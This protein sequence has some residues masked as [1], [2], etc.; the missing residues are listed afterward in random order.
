VGG[1]VAG[2]VAVLLV[3]G[4]WWWCYHKSEKERKVSPFVVLLDLYGSIDVNDPG[5]ASPSSCQSIEIHWSPLIPSFTHA[6]RLCRLHALD[7]QAFA[8]SS[9][10]I[11]RE[12]LI[13][14]RSTC[15]TGSGIR[16]EKDGPR[17]RKRWISSCS[18][19]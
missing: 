7:G 14:W 19:S 2:V 15:G 6:Q 16:S 12:S 3:G 13:V 5:T 10:P 18:W 1:I 9:K 8:H 17:G 11:S 4:I